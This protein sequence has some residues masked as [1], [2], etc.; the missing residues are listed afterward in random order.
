MNTF[1]IRYN[2]EWRLK[3][4]EYYQFTK[5]GKCFNSKTGKYIKM[6]VVGY[7]KGFYIKG[8]FMTLKRLKSQLERIPKKEK[9][10]F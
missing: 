1:T 5:D 4:K 6:C 9:L 10:P 2:T 7:S 8:K 3:G